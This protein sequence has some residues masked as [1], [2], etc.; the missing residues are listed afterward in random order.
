MSLRNTVEFT[1]MTLRLVPE[2]LYSVDMSLIV[3]KEFGMVDPEVMEIRYIQNVVTFPTVRI[4][5]AVRHHL[6][7]DDRHQSS[8]RGIGDNLRVDLATTLQKAE[9]RDF[10]SGAATALAFSS[11]TEV[12]FVNFDLST[13]HGLVLSFQL[14]SDNFAQ[15]QKVEGCCFTVHTT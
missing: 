6:A 3:C 2:V 13:E 15:T 10:S 14:N 4:D 5:Y 9:Y 7:F 1:H 12:T 8:R 11:A